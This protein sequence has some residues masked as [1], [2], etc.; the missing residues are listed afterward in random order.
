[1]QRV[2]CTSL[3]PKN[4]HESRVEQDWESVLRRVELDGLEPDGHRVAKQRPC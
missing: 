3:L 1:M 2:Q 4:R